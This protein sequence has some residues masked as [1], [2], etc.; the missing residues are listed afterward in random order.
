MSVKNLRIKF[1]KII[2]AAGKIIKA[3]FL[4]T[5]KIKQKGNGGNFATRTDLAVERFLVKEFTKLTPDFSIYAEEENL[6]PRVS[7]YQWIIDPID[8]TH[9]FY[10]GI[11]YCSISI[12]LVKDNQ[13]VLAFVY[14]PLVD[15]FYSAE[16]GKGAYLGNKKI[17]VSQ[18]ADLAKANAC[19]SQSYDSLRGNKVENYMFNH[20]VCE[21]ERLMINWSV[22]LD[23]CL[24]AQG[25]VDVFVD[26]EG[27]RYDQAAGYLI[28]KEAGAKITDFQGK[29]ANYDN[30]HLLM[31]N[32][33]KLH[34]LV[35]RQ[36]KNIN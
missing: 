22:A 35:I 23:C 1:E 8:G 34:Q 17:S 27:E 13:P 31:T 26:L 25:S 11:P 14:N 21:I 32:G 30:S 2:R 9:N 28:A 29:P 36:L 15:Q 12:A 16:L 33:S 20:L 4:S 6:N 3:D 5:A 10:L 18:N 19:F 7:K 24:L